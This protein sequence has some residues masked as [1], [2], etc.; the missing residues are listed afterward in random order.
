MAPGSAV[1][2]D[3]DSYT[4]AARSRRGPV[5]LVSDTN[6]FRDTVGSATK[7]SVNQVMSAYSL[8]SGRAVVQDAARS[9]PAAATLTPQSPTPSRFTSTMQSMPTPPSAM[10]MKS[11]VS[12]YDDRSVATSTPQGAMMAQQRQQHFAMSGSRSSRSSN[13]GNVYAPGDKLREAPTADGLGV[14]F[15]N[16]VSGTGYSSSPAVNT[17]GSRAGGLSLAGRNTP[18][19]GMATPSTASRQ[20]VS[21]LQRLGGDIKALASKLDAINGSRR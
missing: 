6:T 2:F 17:G 5:P 4:Q 19:G 13:F 21:R 9:P 16:G 11:I 14:R 20:S 3:P 10:S 12:A 18:G 15:S 8:S 7:G 1:R